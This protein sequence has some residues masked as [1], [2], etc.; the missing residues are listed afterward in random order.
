MITK[1][2][3]GVAAGVLL[4]GGGALATAQADPSPSEPKTAAPAVSSPTVTTQSDESQYPGS[5]FTTTTL[6]IRPRVQYRAENIARVVVNAGATDTN[7]RGTVT[8]V[9]NGQTVSARLIGGAASVAV[10][11]SLKP[12]EYAARA[13]YTPNSGSQFKSSHSGVKF[14]RVVKSGSST[15]VQA[16]RISRG[17]RPTVRVQVESDT[18]ITPRGSVTVRISNGSGERHT[19]LASLLNGQA[20]VRFPKVD[21]RGRW[22]ARAVYGGSNVVQS[23]VG[24]DGFRVT[25]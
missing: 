14:F 12:G 15:F 18:R 10:P 9:V 16:A 22:S 20:V 3:A 5:V 2:V 13:N 23:S 6:S 11:R 25:R 1:S 21:S 17:E 8:L 4:V 24:T 7:P 19:E